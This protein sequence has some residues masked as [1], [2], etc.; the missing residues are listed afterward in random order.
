MQTILS[1]HN[2]EGQIQ[3]IIFALNRL[4][5]TEIA[6]IRLVLFSD[7]GLPFNVEDETVWWFCQKNNYLLVTGNRRTVDGED[8]LEM[9]IRRFYAPDILPVLTI[10]NLNRVFWDGAYCESCAESLAEIVL[11]VETLRGI[12]RLSLP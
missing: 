11:D 3:Q 10:G 1:D 8:S 4:G 9:T 7:V 5:L 6:P 2:C 12:T